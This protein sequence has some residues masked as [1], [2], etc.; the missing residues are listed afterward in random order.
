MKI[1]EGFHIVQIPKAK[2]PFKAAYGVYI[3]NLV[4]VAGEEQEKTGV[5][6]ELEIMTEEAFKDFRKK[7]NRKN[8]FKR[9]ED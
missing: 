1:E 4:R 9:N 5:Y 7:E 8:L 6:E 3:I 2:L